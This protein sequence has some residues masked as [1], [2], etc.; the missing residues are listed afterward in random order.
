MGVY[1]P[2]GT[3]KLPVDDPST[4]SIG[5]SRDLKSCGGPYG[6]SSAVVCGEKNGVWWDDATNIF[7]IQSLL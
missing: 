4:N 6:E 1:F 5:G 2:S 3:A 7:E